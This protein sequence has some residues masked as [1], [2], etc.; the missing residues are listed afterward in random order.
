MADAVADEVSVARAALAAAEQRLA[1]YRARLASAGLTPAGR[2][3]RPLHNAVAAAR[4]RLIYL[5]AI[6]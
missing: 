2:D 5:D 6:P 4:R 1:A 3:L